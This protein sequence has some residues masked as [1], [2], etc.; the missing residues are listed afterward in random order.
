MTTP[1]ALEN[2]CTAPA[3]GMLLIIVSL[4]KQYIFYNITT[5]GAVDAFSP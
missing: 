1:A 5:G 2:D 4:T 3:S